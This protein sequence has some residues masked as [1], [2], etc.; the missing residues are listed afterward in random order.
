VVVVVKQVGR[1]FWES[2]SRDDDMRD[3]LVESKV[4]EVLVELL[5]R[6]R[7]PMEKQ[8]AKAEQAL[9][10]LTTAVEDLRG[11][12]ESL[13]AETGRNRSPRRSSPSNIYASIALSIL[14]LVGGVLI[15]MGWRS[16][17]TKTLN[18]TPQ[19]PLHAE[20]TSQRYANDRLLINFTDA[21][22]K[23]K[24]AIFRLEDGGTPFAI[25]DAPTEKKPDVP[26][27]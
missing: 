24:L 11:E 26:V 25:I 6:L 8:N 15:G 13:K 5:N 20:V 7:A 27:P 12:L 9:T 18:I 14:L 23:P 22:N 3:D 4:N 21:E 16:H 17:G 2:E 10:Q 19:L 1:P